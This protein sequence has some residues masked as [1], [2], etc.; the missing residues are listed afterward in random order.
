MRLDTPP[1]GRRSAPYHGGISGVVVCMLATIASATAAQGPVVNTVYP[2]GGQAGQAVEVTLAGEGIEGV[3]TLHCNASG[4]TSERLGSGLFRLTLPGDV[5]PGTYDLWA[6]SD[7]G[8]S[9]PRTF[10][11]GTRGELLESEPNDFGSPAAVSLGTVINGRIDKAGDEDCF[12]IDAKRGQ[13][14]IIE[15]WAKRIDSRLHAVV[16][17]FAGTTRL[18]K[19]GRQHFG[20]DPLIDF[21][22]PADGQYTVRLQ[23]L[24]ATAST[25]HTY[26]LTVDTGPRIAFTLPSVVQRGRGGRVSAYGWNLLS[27]VASGE[28]TSESHAMDRLEIDIPESLAQESATLPMPLQPAEALLDGFAYHH[29]G[30]NV[31][32][33]IGVTDSP[34]LL[35]TIDNH[36]PSTAQEIPCPCEVSGQLAAAGERDWFS[37]QSRRGEVFCLEGMADRIQS[38]LD[39]QISVFDALG[40]HE[41]ARFDDDVPT[42]DGPLPIGH[43]DPTG[44]WVAAVD[45]RHLICVRDGTGGIHADPRRTYRLAVRREEP[46]FQVLA[47]PHLG[48]PA[49]PTLSRGGRLALELIAFRRRGFDGEIR[50]SAHDLPL[51]MECPD[52]WLGP[53]VD[54]TMMIVSAEAAMTPGRHELKLEADA[55]GIGRR[56][57]RGG[58][59][60]R[61]GTPTPWGRLTSQV[62]LAVAGEARLRIRAQG[63]EALHHHA[64]GTLK[65]RHSPGGIVDVAVEI[66]PDARVPDAPVRLVGIGLP[67][68]ITN[69]SAVIPA[70]ETKGT[71]SFYVPPTFPLGRF[72]L[73]I[74]AE[75]MVP[76]NDPK[77]SERLS[78]YSNPITI[79]VQPA[80]FRVG[81]DNF[82]VTHAHRGETIQVQ[83]SAQRCNGFIGKMHTEIAE[84]GRITDV[85]GLRGRGV[86][87]AG[88]TENGAIQILVNDD[89]P[90]GRV[91]FLRLFTVGVR[92]DEVIFQGSCLVALE[93]LE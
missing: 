22:A 58:T 33:M 87:F 18:L 26:R 42:I 59:L 85:T 73:V 7:A 44:R 34:V 49:G 2:S 4:V 46:D 50:V 3:Q 51:G 81:V 54:R 11:I 60:V 52:V 20:S 65:V 84:P 88:Q 27:D 5:P 77:K 75:K 48:S 19:V 8:I 12:G 39:L 32:V 86:T 89:A 31:P 28:L 91:P 64:Y 69:Q 29:P 92:E 47:V 36:S 82:D 57:V 15:C 16:D 83:F 66:E 90:L 10:A 63:H 53:G 9:A 43:L 76:T 37:I 72:S 67:D 62:N 45:G 1:L 24:T 17:L 70:G 78:A 25:E 35:D 6:V 80:A 14:I 71:I 74:H 38:P 30:S 56:L 93:I 21:V 79:D 61:A 55:V 23:D 40:Q 68:T 13:R 41:L